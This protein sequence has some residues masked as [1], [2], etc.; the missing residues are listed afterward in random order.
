MKKLAL[1]DRHDGMFVFPTFKLLI[2]EY[3]EGYAVRDIGPSVNQKGDPVPRFVFHCSKFR[4]EV[5]LISGE[6]GS[7][8][9]ILAREFSKL[10]AAVIS[11]D[12]HYSQLFAANKDPKTKH[13]KYL[14]DNLLHEKI[15]QFLRKAAADGKVDSLNSLIIPFVSLDNR[16]TV[17]EGFQFELPEYRETLKHSLEQRGFVV[18]TIQL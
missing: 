4:P 6:S 18:R 12:F 2:E 14:R 9:T 1:I 3:L 16:L 13:L 7:G 10:G 5:I 8:K 11:L 15:D 17:I